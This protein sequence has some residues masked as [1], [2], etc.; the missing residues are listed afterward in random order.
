MYQLRQ[1]P[2]VHVVQ[3]AQSR[4]AAFPNRHPVRLRHNWIQH[5]HSRRAHLFGILRAQINIHFIGMIHLGAVHAARLQVHG[6]PRKHAIHFFPGSCQHPHRL[7]KLQR[8]KHPIRRGLRQA[9]HP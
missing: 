1:G 5:I 6:K 7:C 4:L 3:C 2:D 9:L 8:V